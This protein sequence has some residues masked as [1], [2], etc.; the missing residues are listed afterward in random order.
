MLIYIITCTMT[1]NNPDGEVQKSQKELRFE[2]TS[3][4]A[5]L[6]S[7]QE[8]IDCKNQQCQ[9][10]NELLSQTNSNLE[11]LKTD[12]RLQLLKQRQELTKA[13]DTK[14]RKLTDSFKLQVDGYNK[15]QECREGIIESKILGYD[16]L[17]QQLAQGQ[18]DLEEIDFS[19]KIGKL[20]LQISLSEELKCSNQSQIVVDSDE[21]R[22][23]RSKYDAACKMLY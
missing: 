16:K 22:D 2:I 19:Q 13:H 14:L 3:L 8:T 21:L 10:L 15:M 17:V 9:E 11:Q 4:R 23:A 5:Q 6:K 7:Q 1:S 18:L 12:Y 20:V